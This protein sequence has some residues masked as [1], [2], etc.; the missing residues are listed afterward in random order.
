MDESEELTVCP[1]NR[2]DVGLAWTI[3][4]FEIDAR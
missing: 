1:E 3:C 2:K 4:G